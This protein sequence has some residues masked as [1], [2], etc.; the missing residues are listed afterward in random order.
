MVSYSFFWLEAQGQT[1]NPYWGLLW[2]VTPVILTAI[3]KY[4]K[5]LRQKRLATSLSCIALIIAQLLIFQQP[6]TRFI[7]LTVATGLMFINAFNLRQIVVTVIHLG[8]GLCWL[9]NIFNILIDGQNWLLIGAVTMLGLYRLRRYLQQVINTPKFNYI[10]QR[11]AHG[12]LGV[13]VE[14]KNFKLINKYIT[15]VDYWAI[16]IGT[17]EVAILSILYLVAPINAEFQCLLTT[18]ILIGAIIWRYRTQPHNWTIYTVVWLT[19]LLIIGV[20]SLI[21]GSG[22]IIAIAN[23]IMGAIALVIVRQNKRSLW[24]WQ[25]LNVSYVPLIYAVLAMLWRL[26]DRHALTGLLTLSAAIIFLNTK[27]KSD[28][29]NMATDYL[30]YLGIS[31]GIYELVVS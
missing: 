12:I 2:L 7:G 19:E 24:H 14:T 25:E 31:V 6:E 17:A 8:F 5:I 13:G 1:P 28:R 22:L 20:V 26:S 3:A 16:A 29:V 15:A 11:Q 23:I 10:S 21:D 30:A 4:T 27:A 9:A 18:A